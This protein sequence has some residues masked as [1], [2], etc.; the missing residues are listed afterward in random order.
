[1]I[2]PVRELT[3][4]V[5]ELAKEKVP[6]LCSFCPLKTWHSLFVEWPVMLDF[7]LLLPVSKVCGDC[8]ADASRRK[9]TQ[10]AGAGGQRIKSSCTGWC[11]G[12]SN[13]VRFIVLHRQRPFQATQHTGQHWSLISCSVFHGVPVYLLANTCIKL[14]CLVSEAS[15]CEQL[16]QG[17]TQLERGWKWIIES[18]IVIYH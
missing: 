7:F 16:A 18:T 14:N 5:G 11:C 9:P 15:A 13:A 12:H 1:M 2:R 6:F 4:F 8:S 10:W 17:R 3:C